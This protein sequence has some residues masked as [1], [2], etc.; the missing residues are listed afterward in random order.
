MKTHAP[1]LKTAALLAVFAFLCGCR[2]LPLEERI[3]EEGKKQQELLAQKQKDYERLVSRMDF[4]CT[5]VI[6]PNYR[7]EHLNIASVKLAASC[8]R[9][10]MAMAKYIADREKE[11]NIRNV[12]TKVFMEPENYIEIRPTR[13]GEFPCADGKV[14]KMSPAEFAQHLNKVK[15][16][17]ASAAA[18]VMQK[19]QRKSNYEALLLQFSVIELWQME[20]AK[21][22]MHYAKIMS[23]KERMSYRKELQD[24]HLWNDIVTGDLAVRKLTKCNNDKYIIAI[25]Q[26][27]DTAASVARA[28]LIEIERFRRICED[29]HRNKQGLEK[30]LAIAREAARVAPY[31][32]KVTEQ[33]GYAGKL[34]SY[35]MDEWAL[36]WY[37]VNDDLLKK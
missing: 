29:K 33:A 25:V 21:S 14:K 37:D 32:L 17:V 2:S 4:V 3:I 20:L 13:V 9:A 8:R 1:T 35:V 15:N 16:K 11:D 28:V 10:C 22:Y 12:A 23:P 24:Y 27:I 6:I 7:N 5:P 26:E 19:E 18:E 34:H 30:G 31:A 36:N